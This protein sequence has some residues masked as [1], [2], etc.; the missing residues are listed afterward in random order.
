[1]P[2]PSKSPLRRRAT[3]TGNEAADAADASKSPCEEKPQ[4]PPDAL[5]SLAEREREPLYLAIRLWAVNTLDQQTMRAEVV[6]RVFMV[7]RP[8]GEALRVLPS[9]TERIT[10]VDPGWT[11]ELVDSL[12]TLA[13]FNGK[14]TTDEKVKREFFRVN[15][16]QRLGAEGNDDLQPLWFPPNKPELEGNVAVVTYQVSADVQLD[17][18]FHRFPFDVHQLDIKLF[19]PKKHKDKIYEFSCDPAMHI[20]SERILPAALGGK[21]PF[22]VKESVTKS[23]LEWE[24]TEHKAITEMA[25]KEQT[26]ATLCL[27]IQ[28]RPQYYVDKFI[29]R[30]GVLAVLSC[31]SS[32]FECGDLGNRFQITF[33]L[34][35][36]LTAINYS[37]ADMLPNLPYSTSLDY[38]H[39]ACH[40][41]VFM[42]IAQ[43]VL[44]YCLCGV[45]AASTSACAAA[46]EVALAAA[47]AAS[48]G[49]ATASNELPATAAAMVI[50]P[51][52]CTA[53]AIDLYLITLEG[54]WCEPLARYERYV[55]ALLFT[56]WLVWNFGWFYSHRS[57]MAH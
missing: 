24:L 27:I 48:A 10:S 33:T 34:L 22:E 13:V 31:L 39:E 7:F 28:R 32:V 41:F 54:D 5:R 40:Y 14:E 55:M 47:A 2:R 8:R 45:C 15:D 25:H 49:A 23:L 3:R 53:G 1:M 42:I 12:P 18:K 11:D 43:N 56:G 6:F 35:L 21:G 17:M 4:S 36:T 44:F 26:E 46:K 20:A 52:E 9:T 19:L 50:E 37:S 38:Y 30:P 16:A 29:K 57:D 51:P